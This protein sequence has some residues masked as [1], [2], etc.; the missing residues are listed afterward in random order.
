MKGKLLVASTASTAAAAFLAL[1]AACGSGEK[2]PTAT[3]PPNLGAP[4]SCVEPGKS[5]IAHLSQGVSFSFGDICDKVVNEGE[6]TVALGFDTKY[7]SG[8]RAYVFKISSSS[9]SGLAI[10]GVAPN[11]GGQQQAAIV[12][13]SNLGDLLVT[14]SI[15][16]YDPNSHLNHFD[17]VYSS[18]NNAM[19]DAIARTFFVGG[20]YL[21]G[22][23]DERNDNLSYGTKIVVY[24]LNSPE[25]LRP[26]DPNAKP[27]V[28][29]LKKIAA[30]PVLFGWDV[31]VERS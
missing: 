10:V 1:A 6:Y 25:P 28:A 29:V 30:W 16:A 18:E 4:Y 11:I 20:R 8:S 3:P 12:R 21:R 17:S 14:S 22:Y 5:Q 27:E 2:A 31:E 9:P 19:L 24:K 7:A 15:I 23:S 13:H 26:F